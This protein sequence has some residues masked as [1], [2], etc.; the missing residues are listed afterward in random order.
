MSEERPTS[1]SWIFVKVLRQTVDVLQ[2][3]HIPFLVAG[4]VAAKA[5]G[6]RRTTHDIDIFVK[7]SDAPRALRALAEAGFDTEVTYPE[8]LY[9]AFKYHVM[10]DIIFK[11]AGNII[12]DDETLSRARHQ[13]FRGRVLPLVPPEVLMLMKVFALTDTHA[14]NT[15]W[16]HWRDAVSLAR[17]VPLDWEFLYRK[18][19]QLDPRIV[20][21]FLLLSRVEGVKPDTET[22]ARLCEVVGAAAAAEAAR[23]REAAPAEAA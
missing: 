16:R 23:R 14:A 5:Y 18:A 17:N 4:G 8:W 12:V 7:P 6:K 15:H 10:V 1:R 22:V 20:L 9:K 2:A 3:A 13:E 11:S 21:G 19:L